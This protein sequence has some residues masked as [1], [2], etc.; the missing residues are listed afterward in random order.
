[1]RLFD[2][3]KT[4]RLFKFI[5]LLTWVF[6]Y[7]TSCS[8]DLQKETLLLT[9][10][11]VCDHS[12]VIKRAGEKVSPTGGPTGI[13]HGSRMA[14]VNPQASPALCSIPHLTDTATS[15]QAELITHADCGIDILTVLKQLWEMVF[16]ALLCEIHNFHFKW[17]MSL[18]IKIQKHKVI[19]V[20]CARSL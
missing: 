4:L 11:H 13:A 3:L 10:L 8:T 12:R 9:C 2:F 15:H 14:G 5:V 20:I 7:V 1:M 18:N 17:L 16:I 6:C 19:S